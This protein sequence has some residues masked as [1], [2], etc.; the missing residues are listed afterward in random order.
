M[1][2]ETHGLI[3][4][5]IVQWV[6]VSLSMFISYAQTSTAP[7]QIIAKDLSFIKQVN[8]PSTNIPLQ[9]ETLTNLSTVQT[10]PVIIGIGFGILLLSLLIAVGAYVLSK[11]IN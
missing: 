10:A 9:S 4:K 2:G 6:A 1:G 11:K 8:F 5:Q 7:K 3:Y